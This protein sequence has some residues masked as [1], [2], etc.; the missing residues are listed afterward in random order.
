MFP[1]KGYT[2]KGLRHAFETRLRYA[3]VENQ[4]RAQLMGHSLQKLRGREVYG[5]ETELQIRALFA[6][7]IALPMSGWAPRSHD[8]LNKIIDEI[9]EA[10]GFR[11]R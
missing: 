5:E 11:R 7:M 9:L 6:E 3:G 2:I 1:G 8:E 10:K 4:E